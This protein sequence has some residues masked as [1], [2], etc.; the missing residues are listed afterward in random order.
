MKF[1]YIPI[2]WPH[3]S[4]NRSIFSVSECIVPLRVSA[5][6]IRSCVIKTRHCSPLWISNVYNAHRK[7]PWLSGSGWFEDGVVKWT[8]KS[9]RRFS[10]LMI[11]IT[12]KCPYCNSEDIV[13]NGHAPNGKQKYFCKACKRQTRE[14][15]AP[16]CLFR[17]RERKNIEGISRT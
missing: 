14:N 9:L 12:L 6:L 3:Y 5:I 7:P 1:S 8:S 17:K 16:P 10:D 13:P 2:I 11:T 4:S 15:P